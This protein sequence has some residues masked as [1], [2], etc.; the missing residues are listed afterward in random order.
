MSNFDHILDKIKGRR[1]EKD[2]NLHI[3]NEK[4]EF[5]FYKAN[6]PNT[7]IEAHLRSFDL[8]EDYVEFLHEFDSA[9]L[10]QGLGYGGGCS[11]LSPQRVI[12]HWKG[13]SIDHPHYPIAWSDY[14]NGC[15]CVDQDRI[16]SGNGYLTWIESMDPDNPID[17]DLTFTEWLAKL[18]EHEGKEFWIPPFGQ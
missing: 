18:I 3:I 2:G 16:D 11:I 17:I 8:P 12:S 15:V 1:V 6:D 14:S 10:F 9:V 4:N 5:I 13:Y 7:S